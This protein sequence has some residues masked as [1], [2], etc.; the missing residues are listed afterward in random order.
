LSNDITIQLFPL[1][2][3]VAF[4]SNFELLSK[5]DWQSYPCH[6]TGLIYP[7]FICSI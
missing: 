5:S 2:T 1:M 4:H 3:T 6:H 7:W